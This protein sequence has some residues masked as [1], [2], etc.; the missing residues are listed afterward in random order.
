MLNLFDP[1]TDQGL[2]EKLVRKNMDEHE[3]LSKF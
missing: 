1:L 2:N 3:R